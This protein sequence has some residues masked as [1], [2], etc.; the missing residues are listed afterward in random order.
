LTRWGLEPMIYCT[1][2]EH[3]HHY[4]TEAVTINGRLNDMTLRGKLLDVGVLPK[5]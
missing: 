4:T 2:E 5:I 3:D 1:R